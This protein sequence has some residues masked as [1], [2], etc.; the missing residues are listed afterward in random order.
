MCRRTRQ[1]TAIILMG[2][3]RLKVLWLYTDKQAE[4]QPAQ[5]PTRL[6]HIRGYRS[7]SFGGICN[8]AVP[9]CCIWNAAVVSMSIWNATNRITNP[10]TQ[11]RRIANSAVQGSCTSFKDAID[12]GNM[13]ASAYL[14]G[15]TVSDTGEREGDFHQVTIVG[16]RDTTDENNE[17][18]RILILM[19]T[20]VFAQNAYLCPTN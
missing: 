16:Y 3:L 19:N 14:T 15:F 17:P 4:R 13:V 6:S 2:L 12:A 18:I 9:S 7:P 8:S 20:R 5:F 1:H 10:D 11:N